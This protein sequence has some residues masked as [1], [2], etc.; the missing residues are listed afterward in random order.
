MLDQEKDDT[1]KQTEAEL[2]FIQVTLGLLN[3][4]EQNVTLLK[5][6]AEYLEAALNKDYA[7]CKQIMSVMTNNTMLGNLPSIPN[8]AFFE[9]LANAVRV[10][11]ENEASPKKAE[12]LVNKNRLK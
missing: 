12:E 2:A 1:R 3:G 6:C 10:V 8:Q 9:Q 5:Q 7:K 11:S 4:V